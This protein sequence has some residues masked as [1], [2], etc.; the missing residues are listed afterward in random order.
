MNRISTDVSIS[1]CYSFSKSVFPS[2][3]DAFD[4]VTLKGADIHQVKKNF[5][6]F[7]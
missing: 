4:N 7:V 5:N 2:I 6:E 3:T 1:S